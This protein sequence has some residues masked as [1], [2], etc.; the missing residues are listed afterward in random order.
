MSDD[1]AA[2]RFDPEAFRFDGGGCYFVET[3]QR[4]VAARRKAA[5]AVSGETLTPAVDRPEKTED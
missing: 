4:R 5:A 2:A 1:K 3:F